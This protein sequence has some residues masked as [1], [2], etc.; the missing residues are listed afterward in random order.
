MFF[1]PLFLQV[2]NNQESAPLSKSQKLNGSSYLFS[3]IIKVCLDKTDQ[4]GLPLDN[5]LLSKTPGASLFPAAAQQN[6]LNG[7]ISPETG[8]AVANLYQLL[9]QIFPQ[10]TNNAITAAAPFNNAGN[11]KP[12]NIDLNSV[13]FSKTAIFNF[14]QKLID[15]KQFEGK[16]N[17]AINKPVSAG[18]E[19]IIINSAGMVPNGEKLSAETI[20]KLLKEGNTI[21][22][23][24][25]LSDKHQGLLITLVESGSQE[26]GGNEDA[27]KDKAGLNNDQMLIN[28]QGQVFPYQVQSPVLAT[29]VTGDGLTGSEVLNN[30]TGESVYKI[31]LT[32]LNEAGNSDKAINPSLEEMNMLITEGAANS[33]AGTDGLDAFMKQFEQLNAAGKL[34]GSEDVAAV[35]D[36][37]VNV[38]AT[39]A[40]IADVINNAAATTGVQNTAAA[41]TTTGIQNTAAGSNNVAGLAAKVDN[42]GTQVEITK[43]NDLEG[44]MPKAAANDEVSSGENVKPNTVTAEKTDSPVIMQGKSATVI[45]TSAENTA[46]VN[47]SAGNDPVP[48]AETEAKKQSE[49]PAQ[50]AGSKN[51]AVKMS[52]TDIKPGTADSAKEAQPGKLF[53]IERVK[54]EAE[55]QPKG[56]T[57]DNRINESDPIIS[58]AQDVTNEKTPGKQDMKSQ[59]IKAAD[60]GIK[61]TDGDKQTV[62]LRAENGNLSMDKEVKA[63]ASTENHDSIDASGGKADTKSS[64]KEGFTGSGKEQNPQSGEQVLSNAEHTDAKGKTQE[65]HNFS[66]GDVS[67]AADASIK[68]KPEAMPFS[69]MVKTVKAADV[70]KEISRFIQQGNNNHSIT[71]KID[72]ESLGTVKIALNIAEHVVHANIEVEN[73]AAR[74][75]VENNL[76]Q[77][78]NSLNQN[79]V[80]LNS[81]NI[82]LA[83]Q[84]QK[85]NKGFNPRRKTFTMEDD[86]EVDEKNVFRKRQMGYNTYEY[87][88]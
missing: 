62:N 82:S 52:S 4:A 70:M 19:N 2:I 37:A 58:K 51:N 59:E 88:I 80:Q 14:I 56:Q 67:K 9:S 31:N 33:S 36:N 54:T 57:A 28:M 24:D 26:M 30:V 50:E 15:S 12:G 75:M 23:E 34:P 7:K 47:L 65:N 69:E 40:G 49:N 43:G 48:A 84:E 3:D 73:E 35:K 8:S 81:L 13:L 1:N 55:V 22:V 16:V 27:S 68:A 74:K 5:E 25:S 38:A 32:L 87:L 77:L 10:N 41:A 39:D 83:N 46:S 61:I 79:G 21:T 45:N 17:L 60:N 71:L 85:Q 42:P 44:T 6:L 86:K 66:L 63:S 78:Y 76:N 53:R 72:P 64:S 18:Q 29:T 11:E 20:F